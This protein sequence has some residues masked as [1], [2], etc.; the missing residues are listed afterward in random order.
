M[1]FIIFVEG[2]TERNILSDFIRR[3]LNVKFNDNIGVQ[4]VKF[5]GWPDFKKGI[6]KKVNIHLKSPK[7]DEIIA[8]IGLLDLYGPTFFPEDKKTALERYDWGK[9][10]FED[11]IVGQSKYK[12]FFAVHETEAWLLSDTKIFPLEVAKAISDKFQK[13]E[14]VNFDNPPAKLLD[15][16]YSQHLNRSYKKTVDGKSLFTKLEPETA[17]KKCPKLN[18]FLNELVNLAN[19]AGIK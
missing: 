5:N 1:K 11:E 13:P 3:F 6:A 8:A 7:K 16:L 2:K 14:T 4:I 9:K 17:M 10:Y 15:N 12:H 18:E 19:E